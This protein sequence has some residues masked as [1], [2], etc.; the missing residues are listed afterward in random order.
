MKKLLVR[1]LRF[2]DRRRWICAL[3][4]ALLATAVVLP[5]RIVATDPTS[6]VL[7]DLALGA[8]AVLAVSLGARGP[9][10]IA[11]GL[12]GLFF[13]AILLSLIALGAMIVRTLL[14]SS[15]EG[16]L[17]S[18]AYMI[19]IFIGIFNPLTRGT[20][21]RVEELLHEGLHVEGTPRN[22]GR[23]DPVRSGKRRRGR[24]A[25]REMMAHRGSWSYREQ[26][27]SYPNQSEARQ[28][29]RASVALPLTSCGILALILASAT[30]TPAGFPS[31]A[32]L[33]VIG[34]GALSTLLGLGIGLAGFRRGTAVVGIAVALV[35]LGFFF[36]SE[37]EATRERSMPIFL[38]AL[39]AT[40]LLAAYGLFH[41]VRLLS[42]RDQFPYSLYEKDGA[43]V[44]IDRGLFRN[45]PLEGFPL[46]HTVSFRLRGENPQRR[47]HDLQRRF[48][49][50]LQWAAFRRFV[51]VGFRLV[52][53]RDVTFHLYSSHSGKDAE[54]LESYFGQWP[55]DQLDIVTE[56]DPEWTFFRVD[57]Q[58]DVYQKM[59]ARNRRFVFDLV[60]R[61]FDFNREMRIEYFV[62]FEG[63][64]D[65]RAFL[66]RAEGE[67]Y[68]RLDGIGLERTEGT[69]SPGSQDAVI[70]RI[71]E[72]S[73]MGLPKLNSNS[74]RLA[75][76][77]AEA[78]GRLVDW[79][80]QEPDET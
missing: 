40:V 15:G 57:L 75:N 45:A 58:P 14:G 3:V 19:G 77:L 63:E 67:G 21:G 31:P 49:G 8:S 5:F 17:E 34:I 2:T 16:L 76:L 35:P 11:M 56:E 27:Y 78:R 54:R 42:R 61:G 7:L 48:P 29:L 68:H 23:P 9:A 18:P 62:E 64:A 13:S 69:P 10:P 59:A 32:A 74:W 12:V 51:D 72:N 70:V 50:Y 22:Q 38:L 36:A 25:Y 26:S 6:V 20:R 73:R 37:L 52:E 44:A 80:M 66:A 1:F 41:A 43:T 28:R 79:L 4:F 33:W 24:S 65:A 60:D 30:E 55:V 46:H 71:A 39:A 53:G 47:I